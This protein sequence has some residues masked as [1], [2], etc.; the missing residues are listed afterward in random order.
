M[1]CNHFNAH[2]NIYIYIYIILACSCEQVC[3]EHT[4][5][6][7]PMRC[8][9]EPPSAKPWVQQIPGSAQKLKENTQFWLQTS[10][11]NTTFVLPNRCPRSNHHHHPNPLRPPWQPPLPKHECAPMMSC[12]LHWR[13]PNE[14]ASYNCGHPLEPP[15]GVISHLLGPNAHVARITGVWFWYMSQGWNPIM[16]LVP[17]SLKPL[18]LCRQMPRS[19]MIETTNSLGLSKDHVWVPPTMKKQACLTTQLQGNKT[20]SHTPWHTY[21]SYII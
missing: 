20:E 2:H 11:P 18:T 5:L 3:L 10:R 9:A 7:Q 16:F 4:E 8:S 13:N 19:A 14:S 15:S 17:V 21:R 1:L 12:C 6:K